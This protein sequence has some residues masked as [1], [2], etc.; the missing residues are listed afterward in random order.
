M[1]KYFNNFSTT[2][3]KRMLQDLLLVK[4]SECGELNCVQLKKTDTNKLQEC[5]RFL[6]T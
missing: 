3:L 5:H 6:A 1:V 2:L 4:D